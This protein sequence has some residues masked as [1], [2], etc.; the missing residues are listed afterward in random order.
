YRAET[1]RRPD[2]LA[3][4]L[5][6][7]RAT[8]PS[9]ASPAAGRPVLSA[10]ARFRPRAPGPPALCLR[11]RALATAHIPTR[12]SP[13][14]A[15]SPPTAPQPPVSISPGTWHPPSLPPKR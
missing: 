1:G 11:P 10:P 4:P 2:V 6:A 8:G 15:P 12:L 3:L 13:Q 14:P 5:A 9:A 7:E